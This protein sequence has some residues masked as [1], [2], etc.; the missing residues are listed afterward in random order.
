MKKTKLREALKIVRKNEKLVKAYWN[1]KK[2][3]SRL[4]L[5]EFIRREVT[6]DTIT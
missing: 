6:I 4:E 2:T 3:W 5:L 1:E